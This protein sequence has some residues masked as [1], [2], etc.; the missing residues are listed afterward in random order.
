MG[1]SMSRSDGDLA[2]HEAEVEDNVVQVEPPAAP[3]SQAV[4]GA[5]KNQ[6]K[7]K[8]DTPGKKVV[9]TEEQKLTIANFM[10]DNIE[11]WQKELPNFNDNTNRKRKFEEL[12]RLV[13]APTSEIRTWYKSMRTLLARIRRIKSG[14]PAKKLTPGQQW[15]ERNFGF[16]NSYVHGVVNQT[17]APTPKA[18]THAGRT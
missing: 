12:S 14:D 16:L 6:S 5:Q 11:L 1:L 17:M 9:L 7:S 4:A 10:K 8:R 18:D 13:G 15:V 3:A 2:H